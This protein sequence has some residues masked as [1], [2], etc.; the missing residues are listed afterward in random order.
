[1]LTKSHVA[2]RGLI[3]NNTTGEIQHQM[4]LAG[5]RIKATEGGG[6]SRGVGL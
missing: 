4:N 5:G 6:S 2:Q 1:M 3:R